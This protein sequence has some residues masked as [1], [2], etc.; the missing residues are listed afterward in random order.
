MRIH[1]RYLMKRNKW[2]LIVLVLGIAVML[3]PL[4]ACMPPSTA[5]STPAAADPVAHQSDIAALKV[6]MANKAGTGT[7]NALESRMVAVE[8]RP[9]GGSVDTSNFYTKDQMDAAIASA[10]AALKADQTWITGTTHTTP[11]G[12]TTGEYGALISSDGKLELWVDKVSPASDFSTEAGANDQVLYFGRVTVVNKDPDARHSFDLSLF[13]TPDSDCTVADNTTT[14]VPRTQLVTSGDDFSG[15]TTVKALP[16]NIKEGIDFEFRSVGHGSIK[17][18]S[19]R[20]Y[21]IIMDIRQ[22]A[23]TNYEVYWE[24]NWEIFD[25]D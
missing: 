15:F 24:W 1:R 19:Y 21:V 13:I 9:T 16:Y 5:A 10:I 20:K 14:T 6:E 17:A 7:T 25:R 3:M 8:A 23:P 12:T 22:T 18:D 11:A 4:L 2:F